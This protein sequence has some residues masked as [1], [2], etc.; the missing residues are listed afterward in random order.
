[1][2][3]SL[4]YIVVVLIF[5]IGFN[6]LFAQSLQGTV[7][8]KGLNETLVGVNVYLPEYS[9]GTVT[10]F[11]YPEYDYVKVLFDGGSI[12]NP[13]IHLTDNPLREIAKGFILNKLSFEG[14]P[15]GKQFKFETE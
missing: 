15:I 9:K 3:Q 11:G 5:L 13:E 6:R 12:D 7:T 14:E 10:D 8:E 4:K 2:N 1:M